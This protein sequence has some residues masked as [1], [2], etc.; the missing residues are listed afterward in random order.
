[1][2]GY[3][4]V[5]A[6]SRRIGRSLKQQAGYKF[7]NNPYALKRFQGLLASEFVRFSRN[8][9]SQML[10]SSEA[11]VQEGVRRF[12]GDLIELGRALPVE[13]KHILIGILEEA[14]LKYDLYTYK[15]QKRVARL[16]SMVSRRLG[17]DRR[18]RE[19]LILA[20]QLHDIGKIAVPLSIWQK[21]DR[22]T[23]DESD[24][25]RLH[26]L[27]GVSL[28]EAIPHFKEAARI[29]RYNHY[30]NGYPA[31]LDPKGLGLPEQMLSICDYYDALI[32]RRTYKDQVDNVGALQMIACRPYDAKIVRCLASLLVSPTQEIGY[33]ITESGER[34]TM[35]QVITPWDRTLEFYNPANERIGYMNYKPSSYMI[36]YI[37]IEPQ[38]RGRRYSADFID[39]LLIGLLEGKLTGERVEFFRAYIRNPL[40]VKS[41]L[42]RGFAP[43]ELNNEKSL[44]VE[45]VLGGAGEDGKIKIYASDPARRQSLRNY[46]RSPDN[47]DWHVFEVTN[48]PIEGESI[49]IFSTYSLQ[50]K[51][52]LAEYLA[53]TKARIV[54]H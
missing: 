35:R 11:E 26:L 3:T 2:T 52:K 4:S 42:R 30:F 16:A 39:A 15:H 27:I 6:S 53:R 18:T 9:A 33:V 25:K 41:Y 5:V 19:N 7:W 44:S 54:F 51:E 29:L 20:C 34:L 8:V 31:D 24:Y 48:E 37:F 21:T 23:V 38:F 12:A 10:R 47:P 13:E 36:N 32:T 49:K 40:L 22:L 45:V 1:M 50:D 14:A 28:L 46:S 43:S 17:T